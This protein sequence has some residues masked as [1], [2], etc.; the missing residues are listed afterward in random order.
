M[1]DNNIYKNQQI[2]QFQA[3]SQTQSQNTQQ[4]QAMQAANPELLKQNIQ[5]S[6]VANR[7]SETTDDPK[8][9]LYTAAIG[10]PAWFGI[11][12]GMD[13]V[14][15]KCRGNYED[16]VLYKVG[17]FGDKVSNYVTDS[18]LAKSSFGQSVSGGFGKFKNFLRTKVIDKSRILRAFF[19]TPSRPELGMVLD[20][21]M[22]MP[23]F[24]MQDY[25]QHGEKFMSLL[26]HVEDLDCYGATSDEIK[27]F[28]DLI[29][30]AVT[31][32]AKREILQN[33]EVETILKKSRKN[34]TP[35][36]INSEFNAFKALDDNAKLAKLK[37]MKAYELGYK[38]FQTYEKIMK[39][40]HKYLPEILEAT[41]KANKKMQARIWGSNS[42][43]LGKLQKTIF[44]REIYATE[45]A[46]KFAAALGNYNPNENPEL[47][48]VVKQLGLDKKL[49][50]TAFGK[51]F[52][53]YVCM[54][55]EGAT[56][57]FAGGKLVAIMQAGYLADV[58]Y[59][60]AKAEGGFSEKTK[61]FA[62]R[63]TEMVSFFVCMPFALKLMHRI[64]GLQYAGMDKKGVEAYR[65][66]LNAHNQKAMAGGF[67]DKKAWKDSVKNLKEMRN[68][69]V[70]NPIT[71]LF[72]RV[73][74]IVTVGLEQIRP[75]D[76]KAIV[77]EGIWG[78]IKD[79]FRHPKFGVK[80]MAGYPMRAILGMIVLL[81]MFNKIAVKG[82]HL[83]FGKPKHSV[84]DEGK[85]EEKAKDMKSQPLPP[86]QLQ[87]SNQLKQTPQTQTVTQQ[88]TQNTTNTQSNLLD[89]YKN[90]Q[91]NTTKTTTTTTTTTTTNV[92]KKDDK[93][94][95]EPVRTYIP[96][97]VGVQVQSN[98][99]LSAADAAL[100]RAEGAEK[101]ALQTLKMN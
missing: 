66:A 10:V 89:K 26:K 56:N 30:R 3:M 58:I 19:D 23:G 90:G 27:K 50:K 43:K 72:K 99:D 11:T 96:S 22:G 98:E 87:Q 71:K 7:V 12:Q 8:G 31:P 88:T 48:K 100:R 86:Q 92:D 45:N 40:H 69:G 80:Q 20:Q 70:K 33:A 75:Y 84:L 65:Q 15:K 44:G 62:E 55:T 95:T 37:D 101:L 53:K 24:L 76:N 54:I 97:P 64:G 2:P 34:L 4:Q 63:F 41:N 94:Q 28:K 21:Y 16:T 60:S 17:N 51:G 52:L 32:E 73:G 93:K 67:A 82:S 59:K 74:R 6:Y 81:P 13:Y 46:N 42:S 47:D 57:R 91:N 14:N 5:D 83:I 29:E 49:P 85:E 79:L 38:D 9:M 39:E 36:Q 77:R 18:K 25:P 35:A 61:S 68:A 1:L 78:K